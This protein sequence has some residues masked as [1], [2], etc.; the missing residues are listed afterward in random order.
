MVKAK[1]RA[2][3]SM[4]PPPTLSVRKLL[5]SPQ[6]PGSGTWRENVPGRREGVLATACLHA[7]LVLLAECKHDHLRG[8]LRAAQS[9]GARK[10]VDDWGLPLAGSEPPE[11]AGGPAFHELPS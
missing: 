2:C 1:G 4:G 11:E 6:P 8:R 3:E 10:Q 5:S 9:Q 7:C